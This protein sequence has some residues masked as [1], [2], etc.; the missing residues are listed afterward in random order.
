MRMTFSRSA[1]L[2]ALSLTVLLRMGP[3]AQRPDTDL[4]TRLDAT[5]SDTFK[6][7]A[8]G[9]A[10]IV[11]HDGKPVFRKGYGL[12]NLETKTPMRPDMVFQIGSVTKQ[13]T[14]TAV[15]ILAERGKLSFEDD[16][17]LY[18]PNYPNK[19]AKIT[20]EHLLTH[21]S[22]IKSYTEDPKWPALWRED[23][24]PAQIID[25]TKDLPLEFAPGTKFNYNNTA[26]TMLGVIIE[27]A[28]GLPYADFLRRNLF[29]P[30]GMSHTLYGSLTQ[31]IP[32]RAAGYTRGADGWENA[33]YLS[34]TQPY[35]AGALMSNVDDLALWE[36]AVAS[37]KLIS[38][39]SW[40]RAF[41]GFKLAS[42]EPTHYGYGWELDE[43][44]GRKVIHHG[45]GIPGYASETLRM[46]EEHVYV[47]VLANSDDS[48]TDLNFLATILAAEVIGRPYREPTRI[49][50]SD[51]VLES[52]VGVYRIDETS[53]RTI[54]REGDRLFMERSGGSKVEIHPSAE[55][56][57]FR[58]RSFQRLS[59]RK[60]KS[61]RIVELVSQIGNQR[62]VAH[63]IPSP[64]Q[65]P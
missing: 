46:P 16:I 51:A 60:D 9:A 49:R 48:P 44:Q 58:S 6:A 26:Y 13:F 41:A 3:L 34:L 31:I 47:A 53:T 39:A 56:T 57:F 40:E 61:G 29:E 63:R 10:V 36:G 27:K 38:Q 5:L 37:R 33:P 7:D 54:T 59:F 35:S 62:D 21:T 23:L 18:F 14:S 28:S 4:S 8:P 30:L 24:T 20:I 1:L 19:G 2:S 42:G 45:G 32:N 64:L 25:L 43:Y 12:A 55:G 50:L 22:G 65:G 52:Y 17:S 11:V 15:L